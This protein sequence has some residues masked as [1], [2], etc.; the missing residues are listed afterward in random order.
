[1]EAGM[2]LAHL[3]SVLVVLSGIAVA[4]ETNFSAGPQYLSITGATML[5][6]IGTPSFS[7]DAPLAAV[8]EL[9][10]IGPTV[11]EQSYV[12][13]PVLEH[14]AN[15]FPIYYGYPEIPVVELVN[16]ES[17]PELPPSITGEESQLTTAE[18][19][20]HRGYGETVGEAAAYW[21]TRPSSTRHVYTNADIGRESDGQAWAKAQ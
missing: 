1:M 3:V 15:L 19:L 21:K 20:E 7:I 10:Q 18:A 13:N 14:Q 6:S 11:S 2:R 9:P 4:Q 12:A 5:R 17:T 8:T 16:T